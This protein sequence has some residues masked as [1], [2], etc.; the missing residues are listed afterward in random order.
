MAGVGEN[1]AGRAV[2]FTYLEA[3][4]RGDAAFM[5]EVLTVFS[6]EAVEWIDSLD[7]RG[8]WATVVHT[9]KGT[10]RT[11]GANALGDLCARAEEQGAQALP[12]LRTA[13]QAV[14]AEI[15]GYL[16]LKAS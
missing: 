13:L 10:A 11:I 8:D 15:E 3:Y 5:R 6:S 7:P 16:T 2:D 9:M 14:L 4:T 1:Q 12:G